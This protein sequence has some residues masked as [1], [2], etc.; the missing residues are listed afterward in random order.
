MR[1]PPRLPRLRIATI[2]GGV[3][4]FLF[5]VALLHLL[6]PDASLLNTLRDPEAASL[7][8]NT[9]ARTGV[10]LISAVLACLFL[11]IP[12]TANNYTPQL[13][14]LFARSWTNRLVLGLFTLSAAYA[15]WLNGLMREATV[16][17][18][19]LLVGLALVI[20]TLATLLPY[21]FYVLHSLDPEA[22][23]GR[24]AALVTAAMEHDGRGPVEVRQRHLAWRIHQLGN[25]ALRAVERG[26]RDVALAAVEAVER[27][28]HAYLAV[29][30]RHPAAWF[31]VGRDH[32]PGL[33]REALALV[34]ASGT[35]VERELLGQLGH[36]FDTALV[37]M[38]DVVSAIGR[39]N[40]R[41]AAAASVADDTAALDLAIRAFNNL[42]R[43]AVKGGHIHALYDLLYQLRLLAIALWQRHPNRTVAIA[44]HLT[45][46]G[47]MAADRGLPFAQE[48]AAYDLAAIAEAG[49]EAGAPEAE[50]VVS[51]LLSMESPQPTAETPPATPAMVRARLLLAA[52]LAH[53]HA[54]ALVTRLQASL[55]PL[56]AAL[57]EAQARHL[58]AQDDPWFWEI[59]D[60]Q[61][62]LDYLPPERRDHLEAVVT[63]LLQR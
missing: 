6:T 63:P 8:A 39:V 47:T 51:V 9:L 29:K 36:T 17:R 28:G 48:L 27:C 50:S 13:I 1:G 38:G 25:I 32:F 22:I 15:V 12:L 49:V 10:A 37:R 54:D 16:P 20:T 2:A 4:L 33:G 56:P 41:L 53:H 59:T 21:L 11:A 23:I 24:V 14:E 62:N 30:P 34:N 3:A 44:R 40:R 5:L 45:T 31:E 60:R 61:Q 57:I 55:S 7:L 26:D 46:Y 18:L 19:H 58:L 35:W 52:A 42:L 43:E